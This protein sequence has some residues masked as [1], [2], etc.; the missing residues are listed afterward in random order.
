MNFRES[1]FRLFFV[2]ISL[3]VAYI[4]SSAQTSV[5]SSVS[6]YQIGITSQ[7]AGTEISLKLSWRFQSYNSKPKHIN[8]R[9]DKS[10]HSPKSVNFSKDGKKFYIQSLEGYTT[11]VYDTDSMKLLKIIVH[12]FKKSDSLLFINGESSVFG[13]KYR[14]HH[15]NHNVFKGKPVESCM[16]HDG[17]YLW[18]TYYRREFD[19]NAECPS[20]VAI[21]DTE[22][23]SVVRVMPSGPLPKMIACSPDNN[24]IAVTHWGDNTCGII[25]ISSDSVKNFRYVAHLIVDYKAKLDFGAQAVNRD[26]QCGHCLRGT[27]FTPDGKYLL[28]GKMGGTGGIAI[29]TIPDFEYLGTVTGQKNNLRHMI[30]SGE[31]LIISTNSTG[32]VQKAPLKEIIEAKNSVPGKTASYTGWISCHAGSGV[33][34]IDIST[35]GKYIFAAVN[36]LCKIVVI[37]SSDMKIVCSVKS[38]AYPVG[39]ALSPDGTKLVVTSQGKSEKGGN[40]VMVYE[41]F[42]HK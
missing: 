25:D 18:V 42:Y 36:N 27:V 9:F 37:R 8:D 4:H 41:V 1:F 20:A 7:P 23:D 10:I 21:I 24:Y 40:S 6:R 29:F 11:S 39:M 3:S 35:D 19:L 30:I 28:I 34:T 33:R 22:T 32:F 2:F 26:Q 38:D 14:D 15:K 13:Y 12:D 16:S 17:K 31:D 5:D